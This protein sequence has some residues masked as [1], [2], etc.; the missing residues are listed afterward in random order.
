MHDT[1]AILTTS[2]GRSTWVRTI[3]V[4]ARWLQ[5]RRDRR[6]LESMT[7]SQLRDIGLDR[8]YIEYVI[9]NGRD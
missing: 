1:R 4:I 5:G 8:V 3:S 6:L 2:R 9:H 7:D